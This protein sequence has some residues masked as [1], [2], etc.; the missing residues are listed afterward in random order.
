MKT[1]HY[2]KHILWMKYVLP[3]IL[4]LVA[5]GLAAP[6]MV[7]D[8][9]NFGVGAIIALVLLLEAWVIW[10][11]FG[12]LARVEVSLTE[13]GIDYHGKKG[14]IEIPFEEIDEITQPSI[15][16]TGGWIK[17]RSGEKTIRLTVVLE[18]IGEFVRDLKDSLDRLQLSDKYDRGKLFRFYKTAT[19]SDQSWA[20]VYELF[21]KLLLLLLAEAAIGVAIAQLEE[22]ERT[23]D[24]LMILCPAAFAVFVV[25][26][27]VIAEV[28]VGRHFAKSTD[29]AEFSVPGRDRAFESKVFKRTLWVGGII[30]ALLSVASI[31]LL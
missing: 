7:S 29:E 31:A 30:G 23:K 13:N 14:R 25:V 8:R 1:H 11:I 18:G 24:L 6:M 20:R 17:I 27:Y 15:R 16:Y 5:I 22:R 21:F 19:Y 12:R 2:R 26:G 10:R 3:A 28:I 4:L 9:G